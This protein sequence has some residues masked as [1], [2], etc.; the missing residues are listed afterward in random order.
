[1]V[2]WEGQYSDRLLEIIDWC[3]NLNHY[4]RPQSVYA[5]QK[6]LVEAVELPEPPAEPEPPEAGGWFGRFVDKVK[7]PK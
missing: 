4:Y 2:R 7:K 5:L 3:L 6:A 1:M